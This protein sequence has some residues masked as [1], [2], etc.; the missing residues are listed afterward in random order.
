MMNGFA[1]PGFRWSFERSGRVAVVFAVVLASSHCGAAEVTANS[2]MPA[3]AASG[4]AHSRA[5]PPHAAGSTLDRRVDLL[6]AEL[7]LSADQR[8]QVRALLQGQREQVQRVWN[9]ATVPPAMRV[10]RTQAISDKTAESIRALLDEEQ[11]KAY[12]QP[13]LRETSVGAQGAAV[14][15]WTAPGATH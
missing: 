13:R 4:A 10:G 6:A 7:H 12:I 5:A 15:A 1:G 8:I 2:P 14:D 9:D 11:R 3:V